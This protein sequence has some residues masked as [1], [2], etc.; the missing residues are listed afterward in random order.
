MK[1]LMIEDVTQ[2]V[3]SNIGIFIWSNSIVVIEYRSQTLYGYF[4]FN[5]ITGK[6]TPLQFR[7]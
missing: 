1:K 6:T 3:E 5:K 7:K 2:Y 4:E